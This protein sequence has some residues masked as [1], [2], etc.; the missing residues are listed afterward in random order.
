MA[1]A[2]F[3]GFGPLFS[4]FTQLLEANRCS[5]A[6]REAV[7]MMRQVRSS[8][9][10]INMVGESYEDWQTTGLPHLSMKMGQAFEVEVHSGR[11]SER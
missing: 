9:P 11:A 8:V 10:E 1:F 2:D 4:S 7:A 6:R 3:Q 5:R